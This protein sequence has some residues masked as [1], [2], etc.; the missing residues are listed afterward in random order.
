MHDYQRDNRFRSAERLRKRN[1][2]LKVQ[3]RGDR[4][5]G[6][7]FVLYTHPNHCEWPRLGVTVSR[8]VGSAVERNWW[9]RRIRE[10]FRTSKRHFPGGHD[11]VVIV[12]AEADREAFDRLKQELLGLVGSD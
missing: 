3:N 11:Y 7:R 1:E 9:K 8:K 5:D 12:K 10:I 6:D 4:S 2:Y